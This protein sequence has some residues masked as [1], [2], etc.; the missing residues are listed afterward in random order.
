MKKILLPGLI[1]FGLY[2]NAQVNVTA[3]SGTAAATYT[4]LKGAFDAINTGTHQ[5]M[6]NLSITANTTETATAVL[7][8]STTYTSIMIKPAVAAMIS[9]SVDNNSI[10]RILG[11]NVTIDGSMTT[12]GVSRDLTFTNTSTTTPSVITLGSPTSTAP[13][14]N[15]TIKNSTFINGNSGYTNFVMSNGAEHSAAGA[16][17]FNNITIQNNAIKKGLNAI[18]IFGDS[19]VATNG[20]NLLITGN[21]FDTEIL[22]YGIYVAGVG[23]TSN[24]TD[25]T[26]DINRT[27][28]GLSIGIRMDTGTNNATVNGNTITV[29]NTLTNGFNFGAGIYVSPGAA[30]V[31]TKVHDNTI[32]EIKGFFYYNNNGGISLSGASPNVSIY[33]NKISGLKNNNTAVGMQGISLS[34][35]STA[36]NTIAYNNI[37]SDVQ[38]SAAA[39]NS[40]IVVYSGAGYK[41]YNN[42]VN[43]NTS[44]AE[45]GISAALNITSGVTSANAL[46][47]RNNIFANNKTSGTRYAIYST[48]ANTVFGNINYNDYHTTGTALGY[49][50]SANK[51]TLADVQAG[52]GGN[53]NS[54]NVS[55]VFVSQTDLQLSPTGNS[56]LDN[57]AISLPEVTMDFAGNPRGATPDMGGYEFTS[58]NLAV[59]DV[60]NT[61]IDISVY[62][63]PFADI[64]KISDVK[65]IKSIS[66]IDA[67]GRNLKT[68]APA[69]ELNLSDLK[70]GLY[71]VSLQ[72][73][74][75]SEKTYK[76]IK[77]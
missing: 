61:G 17:F 30:N 6:I 70:A 24:F 38:A 9:G 35:T 18:Y 34:S 60:D 32:S 36:A 3:S 63:N 40:G 2:A 16:G 12:G 50:G 20:N 54:L 7:N 76:V 64:L 14:A 56:S 66:I 53:A 48:A 23:G 10:V 69:S 21:T 58:T 39:V 57:A 33:S 75:G 27:I 51:T 41:I 65:G 5:G 8:A 19:S 62:P 72:F 43:L 71:I 13:V 15:V 37:I 25:N 44:N 22:Q 4:T 55:P 28:T 73:E 31:S 59:S 45:T 46:D 42:T 52:F 26:I 29:K 67:S 11:S 1:L 74:N 47:I 49:I 68:L 77:K